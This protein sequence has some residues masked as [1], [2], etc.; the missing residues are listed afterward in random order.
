MVAGSKDTALAASQSTPAL[1]T[2]NDEMGKFVKDQ[3][4]EP[5]GAPKRRSSVVHKVDLKE[6]LE[7]D[8]PAIV[9]RQPNLRAGL[10]NDSPKKAQTLD[11]LAG[12]PGKRHSLLSQM[13][14]RSLSI[15]E[16][17]NNV[18]KAVDYFSMVKKVN[19]M[20]QDIRSGPRALIKQTSLPELHGKNDRGG[21]KDAAG[22]SRKGSK[23]NIPPADAKKAEEPKKEEEAKPMNARAKFLAAMGLPQDRKSLLASNALKALAS[24]GSED[25]AGG[26]EKKEEKKPANRSSIGGSMHTGKNTL[27]ARLRERT[28]ITVE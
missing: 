15:D 1:D 26:G 11:G 3:F 25:N 22:G 27:L 20:S 7:I 14:K 16:M 21:S 18:Q 2:A 24:A 17:D 19:E 4:K 28:S 5:D 9:M 12:S 23:G 13:E 6:A 10:L 8:R